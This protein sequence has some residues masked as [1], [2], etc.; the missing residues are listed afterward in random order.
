M[1]S[2]DSSH[3]I[4]PKRVIFEKKFRVE[5]KHEKIA[6]I[7]VFYTSCTLKINTSDKLPQLHIASTIASSYMQKYPCGAFRPIC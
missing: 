5:K 6:Q 2:I 1:R 7:P 4:S 3:K